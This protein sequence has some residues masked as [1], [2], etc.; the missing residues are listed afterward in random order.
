MPEPS[1]DESTTPRRSGSSS[2]LR[3]TNLRGNAFAPLSEHD[4]DE[5]DEEDDEVFI[6]PDPS[7]VVKYVLGEL[8]QAKK[9]SLLHTIFDENFPSMQYLC[10]TDLVAIP[11]LK[12]GATSSGYLPLWIQTTLMQLIAYFRLWQL[13]DFENR[14]D[15]WS[16][17]DSAWM[18]ITPEEWKTFVRSPITRDMVRQLTTSAFEHSGKSHSGVQST[19]T[20]T[21]VRTL[22]DEWD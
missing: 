8:L 12:C 21:T 20:S 5:D 14:E 15:P 3:P 2:R 10:G 18:A 6:P 7:D 4:S 17:S 22:D 11:N 19:T 9:G 1:P 13:E 16:L